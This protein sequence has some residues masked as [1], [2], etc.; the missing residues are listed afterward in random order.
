MFVPERKGKQQQRAAF[1]VT[2]DY[3]IGLK[4]LAVPG[5]PLPGGEKLEPLI[6]RRQMLW[7]FEATPGRLRLAEIA[8]DIDGGDAA[9]FRPCRR[10]RRSALNRGRDG[11]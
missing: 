9:R 8:D 10:L 11:H 4:M 3:D 2:R 6:R 1:R 7:V 5:L